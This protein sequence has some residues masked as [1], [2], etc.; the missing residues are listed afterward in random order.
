MN[1]TRERAQMFLQGWIDLPSAARIIGFVFFQGRKRAK[2]RIWR[3]N[4]HQRAPA[5][6]T[7]YRPAD[8]SPLVALF[9]GTFFGLG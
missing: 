4:A 9:V 6:T 7:N 5:R 2:T 8:G 1:L 3:T